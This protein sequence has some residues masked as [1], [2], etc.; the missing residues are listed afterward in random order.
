MNFGNDKR[1]TRLED[2]ILRLNSSFQFFSINK[3]L[4]IRDLKILEKF[5]GFHKVIENKAR[6]CLER[7]KTSKILFNPDELE[8]MIDDITFARKLTKVISSSPVLD[9]VKKNVVIKF[10]KNNP[11]LKGKFEY[12]NQ[13]IVLGTKK[14]KNTFVKLLNDDYL[15]SELTKQYYDSLAKDRID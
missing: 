7:I 12:N 8:S 1:F 10:T 14:S 13:Q 4:F 11:A 5:F 3:N 15:V 2:D 6:N 9:K